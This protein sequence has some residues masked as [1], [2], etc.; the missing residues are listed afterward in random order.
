M[1][2]QPGAFGFGLFFVEFSTVCVAG[3]S[4]GALHA[5]AVRFLMF[6]LS[7]WPRSSIGSSAARC[8]ADEGKK[9]E[10]QV[11]TST[12]AHTASR[13]AVPAGGVHSLPRGKERTKK[14]RQRLPPLETAPLPLCKEKDE[15]SHKRS[16][17]CA[18]TQANTSGR[19]RKQEILLQQ[20][21]LGRALMRPRWRRLAKAKAPAALQKPSG[22]GV[23][24][25]IK[26]LGSFS[27]AISLWND[28]EMAP[29]PVQRSA[30]LD[31]VE[32]GCMRV[33]RRS[34][35]NIRS[36]YPKINSISPCNIPPPM[37]K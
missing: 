1:D 37:I 12:D 7:R 18:S 4:H 17:C 15:R 36:S 6:I 14:A 16:L 3:R 19:R 20:T 11:T 5:L 9:A 28:K 32:V 23:P 8:A 24:R 21:H 29:T 2:M 26:P 34:R 31:G 22:G 13:R 10:F 30:Q 35:L 27:F 25:G 33:E